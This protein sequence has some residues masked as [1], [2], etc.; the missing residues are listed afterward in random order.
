MIKTLNSLGVR[1]SFLN[2]MKDSY[3]K[4]IVTITLNGE[5]F[6]GFTLNIRK[7]TRMLVLPLLLNALLQVL[8]RA[9][10]LENDLDF[11]IT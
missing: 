11:Q 8:A 3:E 1:G 4:P 10:R 9:I 7:K 6:K 5:R 2:P